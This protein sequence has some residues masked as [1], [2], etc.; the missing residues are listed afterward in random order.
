MSTILLRHP[1]RCHSW[2]L[3]SMVSWRAGRMVAELPPPPLM[4]GR[5]DPGPKRPRF[6]GGAP[7]AD[8]SDW[9]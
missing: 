8:L 1:A 7:A 9:G 4:R 5:G 3:A 2:T 6:T